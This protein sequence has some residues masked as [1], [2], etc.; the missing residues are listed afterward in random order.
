[1]LY[2]AVG[3]LLVETFPRECEEAGFTKK[4]IQAAM[5]AG[6]ASDSP[7]S[8][9]YGVS[10]FSFLHFSSLFFLLFSFLL[11]SFPRECEEAGFTKKPIQAA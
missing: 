11:S 3:F 9:V 6:S 2:F 4:L 1:M 5:V 8:I 7:I 10:F